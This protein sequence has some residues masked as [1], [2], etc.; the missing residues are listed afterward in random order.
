MIERTGAYTDENVI[1]TEGRIGRLF[2]AQ[3]FR[4]AVFMYA[5]CFHDV[6]SSPAGPAGS[7][8]RE[9]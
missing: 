5:C 9:R 4:S 8:L 7:G 1:G 6:R 2:D 3:N